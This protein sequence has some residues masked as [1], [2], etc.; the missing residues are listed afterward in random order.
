MAL[1]LI[2]ILEAVRPIVDGLRVDRIR[3][4]VAPDGVRDD[5][6]DLSTLELTPAGRVVVWEGPCS[7][8]ARN[9]GGQ[10]TQAHIA[11]GGHDEWAGRYTVKQ[12]LSAVDIPPA[13][14][15]EMLASRDPWLV[16]KTLI[17]IGPT[18]KTYGLSRAIEAELRQGG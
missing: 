15:G 1:D 13:A 3:W 11:E 7:I 4:T 17:C 5:V 14:E 16:G 9:P 6:L 12:P 10:T 2:P 8:V 18:G